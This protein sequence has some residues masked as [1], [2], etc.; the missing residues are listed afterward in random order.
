MQ[1]QQIIDRLGRVEQELKEI[2]KLLKQS[3]PVYGS[4]AWWERE[5]IYGEEQIKKGRFNN[6]KNAESMV[7]QL[8]KGK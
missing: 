2:K 5:I 1:N 8:H 6:Y 7:A 4:D 3:L